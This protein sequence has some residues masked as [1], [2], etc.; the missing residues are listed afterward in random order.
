[1]LEKIIFNVLAFALF[2]ITVLKLIKK[3][4]TSYIYVLAVEFI[5]IVISFIELICSIKL[6]CFFKV[7][8][9]IFSIIIPIAI[10]WLER[11][12]KADFPEL[13][14]T[15][16]AII[17]IKLNKQEE[18]KN[19]I[20]KFLNKNPN[21]YFGHKILAEIYEKQENYEAA[22]SEYMR[23]TDLKRNDIESTYKLCSVLN[24]NKQN[25]EAIEI[26]GETLK[27]KPR[28]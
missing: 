17:L 6:N 16:V 7:I 23:V 2:T 25:D 4:D 1:M 20:S 26:L 27:Q 28:I 10:L 3:N 9:Y 14:N 8:T 5:G 12:N 22:I 11:A 18:A 13:F 15:T 19:I 24:K 21:S